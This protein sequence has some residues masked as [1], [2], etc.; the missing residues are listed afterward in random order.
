MKK[1]IKEIKVF[2]SGAMSID[3]NPIITAE[4]EAQFQ[5]ELAEWHEKRKKNG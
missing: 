5:K 4:D 2:P 3:C 1:I